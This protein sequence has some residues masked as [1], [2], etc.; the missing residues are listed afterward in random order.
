MEEL[1]RRLLFAGS[2]GLRPFNSE[3]YFMAGIKL[4]YLATKNLDITCDRVTLHESVVLVSVCTEITRFHLWD[5]NYTNLF[6]T[7]NIH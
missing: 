6:V 1:S 7:A 4:R 5:R 2:K 3:T